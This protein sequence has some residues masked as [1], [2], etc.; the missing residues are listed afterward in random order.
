[1]KKFN[2]INKAEDFKTEYKLYASGELRVQ[3][4]SLK[5]L[6]NK[7]YWSKN[8][9][10]ILSPNQVRE[11]NIIYRKHLEIREG[12]KDTNIWQQSKDWIRHKFNS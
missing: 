9:E 7:Q 2:F 5:K 1:M 12:D 10:I 6:H 3:S 4:H 8:E 11:I